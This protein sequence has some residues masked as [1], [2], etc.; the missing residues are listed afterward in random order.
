MSKMNNLST[1][2]EE[3]FRFIRASFSLSP[4]KLIPAFKSLR[5]QL[6]ALQGNPLETRSFMYLDIVGWLD[7]KIEGV[8]VQEIRRRNFLE[9]KRKK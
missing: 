8:P 7:S 3:V 4:Q 1:V 2:E 9:H 6:A 5:N